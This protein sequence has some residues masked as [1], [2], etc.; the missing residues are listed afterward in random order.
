[1]FYYYDKGKF[2]ITGAFE[3]VK[4]FKVKTLENVEGISN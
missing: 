4:G 2:F 1:M 3:K